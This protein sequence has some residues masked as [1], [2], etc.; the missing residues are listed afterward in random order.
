MSF[1]SI[2]VGSSRC[3]AVAFS[4]EG[5]VI[6]QQAAAYSPE[7]PEPSFAEMAPEKF[8]QA[9]CDLSRAVASAAS[10]DPIRAF[11]LSSHAETFIPVDSEGQALAPAILN[12]DNRATSE[13]AWLEGSLGRKR[14][15][16]ITGLVVHPM[17]PI[18][19]ILWLRKNRPELFRGRPRFLSVTDYILLRLGIPPSIDYSLASRFLAFDVRERRWS[20]EILRAAELDADQLPV[21]VQAGT[22][23]GKLGAAAS[24]ELGIPSG[25]L[26]V[27][28][29]HDQACAA[30]GVGAIQ[31]S[32]V[33][34][35]MGTYECILAVSGKPSLS[36]AS[37]RASLNSSCHVVPGKYAVLAYFPSGIM[38]E[39]FCDLLRSFPLAHADKQGSAGEEPIYAI[40]ESL[41]PRLPTGLCITPHLIGTCNPDFNPQARAAMYGLSASTDLG[42]IYRGIL[43]G[44]ACEFAQIAELIS[45]AVG[46]FRDIYVTGGGSR[47]RLGLKLRAA[48]ANRR[49]HVMQCPEAVCLGGAILAVVAAGAYATVAE[50][51][52]QLVRESV[53]I[54]PDPALAA[55][56]A[57][58]MQQYRM[59]YSALEPLRVSS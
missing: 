57:H 2:D 59:L 32:R 29:G 55:K 7:F 51:V 30:L 43:E 49:L 41:A 24:A 4:A 52:G 21:P 44:L 14:L 26:V 38:V 33:S 13:A 53:V 8:W 18:P 40:L 11:C 42:Q 58:Q 37:L 9:A 5:K 31:E 6:A 54:E 15:F 50:A 22:V 48:L 56:Y 16:E 39:W 36:E 25:A 45:S 12:M 34:D 27:I 17:Y 28:G 3:K 19:K 23:A 20:P 46:S 1:L 10:N 35:S 47:S